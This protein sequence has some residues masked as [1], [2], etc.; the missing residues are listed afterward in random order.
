MK[1]GARMR[2][3]RIFVFLFL[4]LG[5][6]T[7]PRGAAIDS[8]ILREADSGQD[9]FAV[10]PVTRAALPQ[11]SKWPVT[12]WSGSYRWL[13]EGS[14]PGSAYIK[15]GDRINLV[16]W[17]NQ[18]TSLLTSPGQPATN[19]PDIGVSP[20]G[21]IFVPYVGEV[22]INGMTQSQARLE[23]Q[24]ALG[25]ISQS[26]QVQ[27]QV[28]AGHANTVDMVSGVARPGSIALQSRK[29][30]LLSLIAQSGGIAANLKNPL[31][32]L[33][34]GAKTYEIRADDLFANARRNITMRGGDKVIIKED[35]RYFTALG[36]TGAEELIYFDREQITALEALSMAG[37][38]QDSR[39]N[40]QGV[41]ILRE[42]PEGATAPP[43]QYGPEMRQVIFT[44]DL[45]SA[46][47]LFA[48]RKFRVNP[49]DTVIATESP[50]GPANTVVSL[51]AGLLNI[52]AR[53]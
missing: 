23:V 10:V 29:V 40:L 50:I 2:G 21:T 33:V 31:L 6:C 11:I 32:R 3:A 24:D 37:G 39:A 8:E 35:D 27:L 20:A 46:D 17:D 48:A 14:G 25:T 16:I 45:T 36:A 30:S 26:A 7:L 42:Y 51:V 38:L 41:L 43:R 4:A 28:V 47:G 12:G 9:T 1:W 44:F 53:L 52:R 34:R 18:D 5:A 13:S 15:P 49:K 19:L 22:R